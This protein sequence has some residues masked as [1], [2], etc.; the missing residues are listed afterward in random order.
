MAKFKPAKAKGRGGR[1][2]SGLQAIPCIVIIVS[3]IALISI[4]FALAL[5]SN[6]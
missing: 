2:K 6:S 5:R 4:L 3:I 1:K